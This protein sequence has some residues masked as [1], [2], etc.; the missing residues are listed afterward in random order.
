MVLNI[1]LRDNLNI[2]LSLDKMSE[3][4]R[5]RGFFHDKLYLP[6][7]KLRNS[8]AFSLSPLKLLVC[9][10]GIGRGVRFGQSCVHVDAISET[11]G[12]GL[13]YNR[14]YTFTE[15]F[16]KGCG[17]LMD[18]ITMKG[19][20]CGSDLRVLE[21]LLSFVRCIEG[22]LYIWTLNI[23]K[24]LKIFEV[25]NILR[26]R[27]H[28]YFINSTSGALEIKGNCFLYILSYLPN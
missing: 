15:L 24:I 22:I 5:E 28:I 3:I 21:T 17:M 18:Y 9:D 8:P 16:T 26:D 27:L 2:R 11:N 20:C 25:I 6:L 7:T 12:A 14:I 10:G 19:N 13:K 1:I 23:N 4:K